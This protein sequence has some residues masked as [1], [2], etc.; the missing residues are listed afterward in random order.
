MS[1]YRE[2]A[3]TDPNHVPCPPHPPK[4]PRVYPPA[5][6]V[7]EYTEEAL[8][9]M[10]DT[11]LQHGTDVQGNVDQGVGTSKAGP[12]IDHTKDAEPLER[13]V[14]PHPCTLCGGI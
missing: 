14:T 8:F 2:G 3:K 1:Q 5:G 10:A 7:I 11:L 4:P 12:S 6:P 9:D 13:R